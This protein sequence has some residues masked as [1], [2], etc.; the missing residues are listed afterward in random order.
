M[1]VTLL[2]TVHASHYGFTWNKHHV[3]VGKSGGFCTDLQKHFLCIAHPLNKLGSA[4]S[5]SVSVFG[6]EH[7]SFISTHDALKWLRIKART[8]NCNIQI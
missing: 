4:A 7:A 2:A 8:V 3:L 5:T 1:L 6:S